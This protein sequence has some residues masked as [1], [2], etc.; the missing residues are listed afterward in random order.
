MMAMPIT[1]LISC[2]FAVWLCDHWREWPNVVQRQSQTLKIRN[3]STIYIPE[4]DGTKT[5]VVK[6]YE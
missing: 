3:R 1:Y 2:D 5:N 6:V 4:L